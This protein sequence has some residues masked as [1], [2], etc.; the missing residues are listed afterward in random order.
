MNDS[1]L[2]DVPSDRDEIVASSQVVL[3]G[4]LSKERLI[5]LI[6]LQREEDSLDYK[7]S[8]DHTG[9]RVTKDKLNMVADVAA[10]A[11]TSGCPVACYFEYSVVRVPIDDGGCG[12]FVAQ[13]TT[14]PFPTTERAC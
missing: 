5:S 14:P 11:N 2:G 4:D 9:R 12:F 13:D 3:D 7:S 8:Y 1:L 10:M 6:G